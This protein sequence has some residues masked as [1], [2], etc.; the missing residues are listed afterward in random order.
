VEKRPDWGD[1]RISVAGMEET[2]RVV[3]GNITRNERERRWRSRYEIGK[4]PEEARIWKKEIT[5]DSQ[6]RRRESAT[7]R[8]NEG[9]L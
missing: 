9:I 8:L 4:V 5:R 2:I 7:L 3:S 6:V 1:T